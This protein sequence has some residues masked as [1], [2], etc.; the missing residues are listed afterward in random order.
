[1]KKTILAL[2][3][4]ALLIFVIPAQSIADETEDIVIMGIKRI[5][6]IVIDISISKNIS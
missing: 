3:T 2:T 1:M 6:L 5:D 4:F